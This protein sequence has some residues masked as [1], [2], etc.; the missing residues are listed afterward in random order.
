VVAGVEASAG[1]YSF[2]F[3]AS[4]SSSQQSRSNAPPQ[5]SQHR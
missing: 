2:T 3:E 1:D 5:P 4:G